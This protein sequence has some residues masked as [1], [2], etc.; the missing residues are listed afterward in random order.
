[1]AKKSQEVV[2]TSCKNKFTGIP[3]RTL[4]GF[5]KFKC[6]SCDSI[7]IYPLTNTNRIVNWVVG[8]CAWSWFI[9]GKVYLFPLAVL[10]GR[11]EKSGWGGNP[12]IEFT[13]LLSLFTFLGI[14]PTYAVVKDIQLRRRQPITDSTLPQKLL[15]KALKAERAGAYEEAA[16]LYNTIISDH[17]GTSAA[18]DA[19][20]CVNVLTKEGK[21]SK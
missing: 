20:Q 7:V 1:M 4:A 5:R 15:K 19:K 9:T 18:D 6:P 12:Y 10:T 11:I 21:I 16:S 3:T 8:I 2:C 14:I 13:I 17:P